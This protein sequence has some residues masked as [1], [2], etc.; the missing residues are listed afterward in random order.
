MSTEAP[1]SVF[2]TVEEAIEDIA[3]GKMVILVDDEQR[4]NEGDLICA[5][6]L[7]TPE[8]V[9][10]M[11]THGRG[12]ICVPMT[13]ERCDQLNLPQVVENKTNTERPS[14]SR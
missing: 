11:T 4:E 1:N 2:A 12:L 10:F 3:A 6:H 7:V 8:A 13:P 9:N 5:A 14:P